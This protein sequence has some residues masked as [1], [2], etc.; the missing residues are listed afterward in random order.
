MLQVNWKCQSISIRRNKGFGEFDFENGSSFNGIVCIP[1][2]S[3]MALI[4]W[5]PAKR[6]CK[7]VKYNRSSN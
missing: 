3:G 2:I 1:L 4:E 5:A 6:R 7:E